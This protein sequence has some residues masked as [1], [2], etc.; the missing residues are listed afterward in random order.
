MKL[1]TT[2]CHQTTGQPRCLSDGHGLYLQT[3]KQRVGDELSRCWLF[4]YSYNGKARCIGLGSFP[5]ISLKDARELAVEQRK[6]LLAGQDPKAAR[7]ALRAASEPAKSSAP[8][9]ATVASGYILLHRKNWKN[10]RHAGQWTDTTAKL[11]FA[12]KPV[13][14]ISADDIDSALRPSWESTHETARRTLNRIFAILE[15]A[16]LKGWRTDPAPEP[17]RMARRLGTV[18][19]VV[20]PHA[21][22][23]YRAIPEFMAKLRAIRSMSARALE[24]AVLNAA[25]A[26]EVLGADWSEI[27]FADKVWK[28]P[29]PRM[30]N[31][32]PH[33]VPL[34]EAA[35]DLLDDLPGSKERVGRAFDISNC[36][37]WELCKRVA[38]PHATT[39]GFRSTFR[40]WCGDMTEA[41]R[42][43]AEAALAHTVGGTE[44]AYRRA[45]ALEKRRVLME[46]WATYCG[47]ADNVVQMT[48]AA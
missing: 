46:S 38:G 7:D 16:E 36:A 28:I 22:L 4:R 23:D 20:K 47:S 19:R 14:E 17:K 26:G 35:L 31:G 39:H 30:K 21:A 8:T 40:D 37:M 33:T 32:K 11:S 15:W 10:A 27:S 9:F 12:D 34:T 2:I 41:P 1:T 6:L 3:T 42:E 45:T 25:R 29:G 18:K 44:G 43:V 13:N 24:F 5:Q 48:E